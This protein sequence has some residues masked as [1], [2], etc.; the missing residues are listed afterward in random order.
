MIFP[1]ASTLAVVVALSLNV[2]A[3]PVAPNEPDHRLVSF[4]TYVRADIRR[5]ELIQC[6][7]DQSIGRQVHCMSIALSNT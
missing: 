7:I 4:A 1:Y 3:L 6:I 5:K 2:A